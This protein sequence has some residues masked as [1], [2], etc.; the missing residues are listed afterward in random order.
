MQQPT[1]ASGEPQE[2]CGRRAAPISG[3]GA[4]HTVQ[5]P[6]SLFLRATDPHLHIQPFPCSSARTC[7]CRCSSWYSCGALPLISSARR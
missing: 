5:A 7:S 3:A 2:S 6:C 1:R 4:G